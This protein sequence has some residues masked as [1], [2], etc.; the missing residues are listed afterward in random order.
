MKK[1][2]DKFDEDFINL[3]KSG[4]L[5]IF[6]IEDLAVKSIDEYKELIHHHIEELL[7]KAVD[8][9]KLIVKKN[10]NGKIADII[11]VTKEKKN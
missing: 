7:Q 1:I 10:K 5:D 9:N 8:E 2:V 4:K 3:N 6:G 11:S